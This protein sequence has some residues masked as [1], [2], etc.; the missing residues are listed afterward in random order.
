M[1]R[2]HRRS[3]T[4]SEPIQIQ[5]P[6]PDYSAF[7]A[8]VALWFQDLSADINSRTGYLIKE[9]KGVYGSRLKQLI[10][11][12]IH[13]SNEIKLIRTSQE[14]RT[15]SLCVY[16]F[17]LFKFFGEYI[18]PASLTL[19]TAYVYYGSPLPLYT[20]LVL[21]SVYC[22][23]LVGF[24]LFLNIQHLL[25]RQWMLWKAQ[26]LFL[27]EQEEAMERA[28]TGIVRPFLIQT[29]E[30]LLCDSKPFVAIKSVYL[31][32]NSDLELMRST[33]FERAEAY[34]KGIPFSELL[35]LGKIS[36]QYLNGLYRL[37]RDSDQR[38]SDALYTLT[39]EIER[40]PA[41]IKR[42]I[43]NS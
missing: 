1:P 29:F 42:Q 10:R 19:G 24:R 28:I 16:L 31:T 23:S 15:Q 6:E 25:S 40:V 39:Q 18:L 41:T 14:I 17:H 34:V 35:V 38:M 13:Q 26:A 4:R 43:T 2:S 9:P 36:K 8:Q 37:V 33:L 32:Y 20:P 3:I 11:Y 27:Q 22:G 5:E 21:I 12:M 30:R 7:R